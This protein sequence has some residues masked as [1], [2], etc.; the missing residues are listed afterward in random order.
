[1]RCLA[2]AEVL[3]R[4]GMEVKFIARQMPDSLI[5]R[6][7]SAGFESICMQPANS[8]SCTGSLAH[9]HWLRMG[10]LEDAK[11]TI[12]TLTTLGDVDWLI[13]DHYGIDATWEQLVRE[14]V[15]RLFVIDDLADRAHVCDLLLDQTLDSGAAERYQKLVPVLCRRLLGPRYALLRSEFI[16]ERTKKPVH[17]G[18]V[19][20]LLV[21]LGG[22]DPGNYTS[23]A[24]DALDLIKK[25]R[26]QVDVV[27][28][29]INVHRGDIERRCREMPDVR[30]HCD[31]L[32]MASLL[33][34][35]DL[36]IGAGGTNTWERACLGL[37][38]IVIAVAPNQ[39]VQ[40]AA[41]AELGAII[42]LP[43]RDLSPQVIAGAITMLMANPDRLCEMSRISAGLVDGRGAERVARELSAAPLVLRRATAADSDALHQW[44]NAEEVRRYSHDSAPIGLDTHRT[45]LMSVLAD[46]ARDL[47]IAEQNDRPV[48]VLRYDRCGTSATVSIYLVP[49]HS[50]QGLGP[51]ILLAGDRWLDHHHP[52]V[53]TVIAEVLPDNKASA[54][55]FIEAGYEQGPETYI[56]RL[57]R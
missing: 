11:E 51:R 57:R 3:A 22:S 44:R 28:G 49:G 2:L 15:G 36:V 39:R 47:L 30:F 13:V 34:A 8:S 26:F 41:M 53:R 24:L 14:H 31:V 21:F 38:S 56:K 43:A 46:Q 4:S 55:A 18:K 16:R 33:A 7:R 10:P 32:D 27:V 35:S 20:R 37:P 45:W 1:M 42:E 5:A 40:T 48:G 54:R 50:G 23:I 17:T 25:R 12:R 6:I 9:S 29:S 52:E 19:N